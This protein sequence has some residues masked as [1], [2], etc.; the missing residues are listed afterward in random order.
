MD[1]LVAL[2]Q[3]PDSWAILGLLFLWG[4]MRMARRMFYQHEKQ[5][6]ERWGQ[7]KT[8]LGITD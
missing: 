1:T 2:A 5:C 7:V 8:K 6:A 4:E 3:D